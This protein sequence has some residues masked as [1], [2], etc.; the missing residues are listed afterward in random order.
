MRQ[1]LAISASSRVVN[2]FYPTSLIYTP[3]TSPNDSVYTSFI[4][5]VSLGETESALYR[6]YFHVNLYKTLF[7]NLQEETSTSRYVAI[8][9]NYIHSI[10]DR[11]CMY[12]CYPE[13]TLI[14]KSQVLHSSITSYIVKDF[15]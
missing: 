8:N 14:V 7:S 15:Q 4:L 13:Y 10:S 2:S 11:L 3:E 12:K 9:F 1:S 6:I 5:V